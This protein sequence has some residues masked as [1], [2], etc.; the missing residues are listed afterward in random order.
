LLIGFV[1]SAVAVA[2]LALAS[3]FVGVGDVSIRALFDPNGSGQALQLLMASRVPRTAALILA[4]VGMA[5]AGLIMQMLARNRFVEPSTAGTSESAALGILAVTLL[6]PDLPVWARM[7]VV[8]GDLAP[9]SPAL[10]PGGAA[11][12]PHAGR[13]HQFHHRVLRLPLRSHA[14]PQ[15]LDDRR[16]FGRSARTV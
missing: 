13:R 16:F 14:V 12:R 3:L 4:G 11:G 9:H 8:P 15:R 5:V 2:T 7:L 6:A 1:L 10:A